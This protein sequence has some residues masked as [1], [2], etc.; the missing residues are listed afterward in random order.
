MYSEKTE[1][2][3]IKSSRPEDS[4]RPPFKRDGRSAAEAI[5]AA[6]AQKQ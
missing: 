2:S 4:G 6:A 3:T 5:A 1:K